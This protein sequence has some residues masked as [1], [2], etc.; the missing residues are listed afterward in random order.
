MYSHS[1]LIN[2]INR[3]TMKNTLILFAVTFCSL[4][5]MAQRPERGEGRRPEGK[6]PQGKE[7]HR[8]GPENRQHM[9]KA[10]NLTEDQKAQ[11]KTL[12]ED[13][14]TKIKALESNE[15]IT[16]KA[17]RD[18][19]FALAQQNHTAMQK[20]LTTEQKQQMEDMKTQMMEKMEAQ[21]LAGL[22]QKLKLTQPQQEKINAMHQKN[23]DAMQKI[24]KNESLD[25]TAKK[26]AAKKL[27]DSLDKDMEKILTKEQLTEWKAM[28]K[29]GPRN[30][31]H[32]RRMHQPEVV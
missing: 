6:H 5:A 27:K 19:R 32:R 26:T 29:K 14:K 9:M 1:I 24:R 21:R 4:S 2:T 30:E 11:M 3:T 23:Q 20:I 22:T 15:N 31:G 28:S 16:V 18:Q 8:G 25:R 7:M 17:Q 10:I 12:K 13:F